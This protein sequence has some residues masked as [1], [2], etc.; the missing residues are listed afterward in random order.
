MYQCHPSKGTGLSN[1]EWR[2][3]RVGF[4]LYRMGRST[5]GSAATT[6]GCSLFLFF[7]TL[8]FFVKFGTVIFSVTSL[9]VIYALVL[10]PALLM[11]AGP[12]RKGCLP[13]RRDSPP[14]ISDPEFHDICKN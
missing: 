12:T 13:C 7:C 14:Q 6:L 9:S 3:E 11:L 2:A 8:R 10:L 1:D 5:V 4:A